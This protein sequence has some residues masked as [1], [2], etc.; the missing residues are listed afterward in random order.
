V[1]R[2]PAAR[3]G[4][5]AISVAFDIRRLVDAHVQRQPHQGIT[6]YTLRLY[7]QLR[8][9]PDEIKVVPVY[10]HPLDPVRIGLDK[11]LQQASALGAL[12]RNLG[13]GIELP[14]ARRRLSARLVG[15]LHRLD[16]SLGSLRAPRALLRVAQRKL[17]EAAYLPRATSPVRADLFHSPV[18][19]L[20][21][22]WRTPALHRVLTVHD[23]IY[24]KR[25][26]LYPL[27]GRVP[28]IRKALD[29]LDPS[30]DFVICDSASTRSDLLEFVDLPADQAHVVPLAAD[31]AFHHPD[32]G[33][34]RGRLAALGLE[35]DRYL[36]ALAQSEKRK[37]ILRLVE[38]FRHS[39]ASADLDLVLVTN[40]TYAPKLAALLGDLSLAGPRVRV[41]TEVDD[42]ELAGLLALATAFVYVPLYE[43][44]GIPTLEAMAA[45]CPVVA[46]DNSSI[47][48]VT[49]DAA[50]Y[51]DAEDAAS[52]VAGLDEIVRDRALRDRLRARGR[53]RARR[54]SWRRTAEETV[55]VYRR[56]LERKAEGAVIPC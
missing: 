17:L 21:D 37:N 51:V 34:G 41:V 23:C 31:E 35:P 1:T 46:A 9:R 56:V 47:P 28:A 14:W 33:A 38:A 25:P 2:G 15:W 39:A 13:A 24:L 27:P 30:R 22:P 44:F 8:E 29:S 40:A 12:G 10:L 55:D 36:L 3:P 16:D 53:E 45:G 18:N 52:I 19:P 11:A 4:G 50:R 26:E 48:E 20:P 5:S 49:A 7:Q 54:F 42:R 43:G 32:P 6:R